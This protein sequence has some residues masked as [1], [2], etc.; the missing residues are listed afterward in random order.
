MQGRSQISRPSEP[1][2]MLTL[3]NHPLDL[4]FETRKIQV[5]AC[6]WRWSIV[7]A[8]QIPRRLKCF[9][10]TRAAGTQL[11]CR[12]LCSHGHLLAGLALHHIEGF[13]SRRILGIK[14]IPRVRNHS[15]PHYCW[16][17][18]VGVPYLACRERSDGREGET[19]WCARNPKAVVNYPRELG[20]AFLCSLETTSQILRRSCGIQHQ[21][22]ACPLWCY[23][24]SGF[25][26]QGKY[27]DLYRNSALDSNWI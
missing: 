20:D 15:F 12:F 13:P 2:D 27:K 6:Q 11:R 14:P 10:H 16:N 26:T 3:W 18:W 9:W 21:N 19:V 23:Q 24:V 22:R 4:H 1:E 17:T 25:E 5:S 7:S 8:P